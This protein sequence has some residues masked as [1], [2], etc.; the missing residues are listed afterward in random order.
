MEIPI[1]ILPGKYPTFI[2]SRL[3]RSFQRFLLLGV[4]TKSLCLDG[5][6]WRGDRIGQLEKIEAIGAIC[7]CGTYALYWNHIAKQLRQDTILTAICK[8]DFRS[9]MAGN[10]YDVDIGGGVGGACTE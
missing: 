1:C 2:T 4:N 7:S 10:D 5:H 6:M 8:K 9:D 3:K